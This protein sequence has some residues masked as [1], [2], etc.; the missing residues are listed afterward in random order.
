[1]RLVTFLIEGVDNRKQVLSVFF[2]LTKVGC[3]FSNTFV[4]I[5]KFGV[6]CIS[7][8]WIESYM[9]NKVQHVEVAGV[10]FSNLYKIIYHSMCNV[11]FLF[12]IIILELFSY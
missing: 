10:L 11:F 12:N 4:Q 1:M 6:R 5:R 7:L 8:E 9:T 2:D 3:D